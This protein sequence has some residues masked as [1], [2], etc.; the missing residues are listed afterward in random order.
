[1][2]WSTNV[3]VDQPL[4]D[5]RAR[6]VAYHLR[7]WGYK[8]SKAWCYKRTP[9]E[10]AST[11]EPSSKEVRDALYSKICCAARTPLERRDMPWTEVLEILESVSDTVAMYAIHHFTANRKSR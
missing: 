6:N 9:S 7:G 2:L 10:I 5:R 3:S 11:L 8:V 4:S 1:M